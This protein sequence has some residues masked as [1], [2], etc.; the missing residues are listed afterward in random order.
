M[1]IVKQRQLS[2]NEIQKYKDDG[3]LVLPEFIDRAR[4]D[5]LVDEIYAALH[6]ET[7]LSRAELGI[8]TSNADRLRQTQAYLRGSLLDELI[9]GEGTK[10]VASQLIGG[11]AVPYNPFTAY[12]GC[13]GGQFDF[14]QDNNYTRHEPAL[15]SINIWVALTDMTPE[16]GCL[17]VEP[18]SHKKGV[19]G[20]IDAGDNVH[21]KLAHDPDHYEALSMRAGDA[22][23]FTRL[24]VHGSGPNTTD[25]P[26]IAYAL[27]Y[28]RD[29][30]EYLD[31]KD[32]A[33]KLLVDNPRFQI[34]P[35]DIFQG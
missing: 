10:S 3:Y 32:N 17:R 12:K 28:H 16:N 6:H 27:Q 15:G 8:A 31:M 9:N 22:V 34:A 5:A 2:E 1:N 14:H 29:D 26:R 20:S 11:P 13:S 24:T 23:A 18:Q 35:M 21:R 33:W 25:T 19:L 7:G 30:V 4:I